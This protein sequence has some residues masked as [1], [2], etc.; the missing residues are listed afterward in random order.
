MQD[1][2]HEIAEKMCE[3]IRQK[4]P[5]ERAEMG[6]SM[7]QTSKS[8]VIR[9]ILEDNPGISQSHLRR[10]LFLK[11]YCDDFDLIARD[12]IVRHLENCAL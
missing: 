7:Y 2:T 11:F 1:T 12:K 5:T 10:E 4:S 3:M 6:S 8:L 9:A